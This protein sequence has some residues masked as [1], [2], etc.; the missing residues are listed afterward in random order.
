MTHARFV[1]LHSPP[2]KIEEVIGIFRDSIL[3]ATQT[4]P[5]FQGARLLA[6]RKIGKTVLVTL[7]QTEAK[8]SATE[9]NG[10]LHQQLVKFNHLLAAPPQRETY[11]LV[12]NL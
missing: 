7:W 3:P 10:F 5:G 4:Q 2:D 11:E 6:D 8:M 9:E 1:T 12:I